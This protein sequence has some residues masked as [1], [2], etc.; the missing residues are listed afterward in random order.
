MKPFRHNRFIILTLF[1]RSIGNSGITKGVCDDALRIE[2]MQYVRSMLNN[3]MDQQDISF[4]FF[5]DMD[6]LEKITFVCFVPAEV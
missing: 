6:L 2:A 1:F 4:I 3:E 5:E